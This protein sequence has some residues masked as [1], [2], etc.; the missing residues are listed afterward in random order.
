M[1]LRE[2][3]TVSQHA[4]YLDPENEA[5]KW[6]ATIINVIIHTCACSCQNVLC[7]EKTFAKIP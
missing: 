3:V 2:N 4:R 5:A 7:E 1:F 6:N